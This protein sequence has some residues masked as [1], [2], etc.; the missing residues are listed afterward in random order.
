MSELNRLT[1]IQAMMKTVIHKMNWAVPMNRANVS[2]KLPKA[3]SGSR[4]RGSQERLRPGVLSRSPAAIIS[5][6]R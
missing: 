3:S 4:I 1:T 2:A 6:L 5:P